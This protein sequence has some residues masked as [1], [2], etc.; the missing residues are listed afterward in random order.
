MG[1]IDERMRFET[2]NDFYIR[3]NIIR[4]L[5]LELTDDKREIYRYYIY[6]NRLLSDMKADGIWEFLAAIDVDEYSES[7]GRLRRYYNKG[8]DH[9]EHRR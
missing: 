5:F 8:G 7:I 1:V 2:Y 3:K 6:A 4:E 9:I